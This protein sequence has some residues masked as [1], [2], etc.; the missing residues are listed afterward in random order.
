MARAKT[1]LCDVESL[2]LVELD[3][4]KQYIIFADAEQVDIV[5]LAQVQGPSALVGATIIPIRRIKGQSLSE[6]IDVYERAKHG[7]Q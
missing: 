2:M 7:Q 3:P 5:N 1:T 4:A 6:A